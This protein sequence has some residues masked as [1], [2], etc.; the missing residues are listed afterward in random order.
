[1]CGRPVKKEL[2]SWK[3][4]ILPASTRPGC[5]NRCKVLAP[6]P[7]ATTHDVTTPICSST[8]ACLHRRHHSNNH[9]TSPQLG[10]TRTPAPITSIP[11]KV[12]HTAHRHK[13]TSHLVPMGLVGPVDDCLVHRTHDT[14]LRLLLSQ[15]C[16]GVRT[17]GRRLYVGTDGYTRG[18]HHPI[19]CG[20]DRRRGGEPNALTRRRRR[21]SVPEMVL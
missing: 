18:S 7:R 1:M 9:K 16:I 10:A 20:R 15:A 14:T 6:A 12:D 4:M 2:I 19:C 5:R 8:S 21:Q 13:Y 17:N 3:V 11:C